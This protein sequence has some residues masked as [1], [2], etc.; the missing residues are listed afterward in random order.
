MQPVTVIAFEDELCELDAGGFCA[1]RLI[2][3]PH[4][5]AEHVVAVQILPFIIIP[6]CA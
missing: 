2:T 3:I 5:I 6:P 1:E 4:A